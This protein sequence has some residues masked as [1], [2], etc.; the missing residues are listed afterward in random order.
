LKGSWRLGFTRLKRFGSSNWERIESSFRALCG[1]GGVLARGS[2]WERIER[3]R[4]GLGERLLVDLLE[5]AATGKELKAECTATFCL[6]CEAASHLHCS[7]WERIERL[8][9]IVVV[10]FV[11]LV[12][13]ATGKELKGRSHQ[14]SSPRKTRSPATTGK[15]L[16]VRTSVGLN[17]A[18]VPR[19]AT[20]KELKGVYR[21]IAPPPP[22]SNW[23]RIES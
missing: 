19:A 9:W 14:R 8:V 12:L 4:R 23:E 21:L 2:N 18:M 16:K 5:P 20:G 10:A 13:A 3:I 22:G 7:N 17:L 6:G 1:R 15:E 11:P